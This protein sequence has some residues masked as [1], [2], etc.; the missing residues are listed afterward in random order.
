MAMDRVNPVNPKIQ[1]IP[2]QTNVAMIL[3]AEV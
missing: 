2:I 3:E 1:S